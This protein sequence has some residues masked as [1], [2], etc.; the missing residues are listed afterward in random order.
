MAMEAIVSG[1]AARAAF[2][3][4]TE[5]FY[6][7]ADRPTD[8]IFI[9]RA[10]LREIFMDATDVESFI[11]RDYRESFPKLLVKFNSNRALAL[12]DIFLGL[13]FSN[14][15]RVS[16]ANEFMDLLFEDGVKNEIE[17]YL[18]SKENNLLKFEREFFGNPIKDARFFEYL[19]FIESCQEFIKETRRSLEIALKSVGSSWESS[20]E[21]ES[22]AISLGIFS[23]FVRAKA[24]NEKANNL[25]LD[26]HLKLAK[27]PQS[28]EIITNWTRSL[29]DKKARLDLQAILREEEAS[30]KEA[31]Y[32]PSEFVPGHELYQ[33]VLRQQGAIIEKI[34]DG[35]IA[36]ARKFADELI[37]HQ[38][39]SSS[40]NFAAKSLSKLAMEA[41]KFGRQ[42]LELEWARRALELA[43]NDGHAAGIAADTYLKLARLEEAQEAFE[44]VI[45][46]GVSAFGRAGLARVLRASGKLDEAL[47]ELQNLLD[48][49]ADG[50]EQREFVWFSYCSVL[51][52]MWRFDDALAAVRISRKEFSNSFL[53]EVTE[54]AILA[55]LGDLDAALEI[56]Q[57]ASV[58]HPEE[59][60]S[61]CG[62]AS[63][64]Q[65][66]GRIDEAEQTYASAHKRFQADPR[67]LVGLANALR[68]SGKFAEANAC[69]NDAISSYPFESSAYCGLAENF[70]DVGDIPSAIAA[71][72]SARSKF[73]LDAVV[74]CGRAN[75][76]K[77][78]GDF[79][80]ALRAYEEN[81][82]DF[83]YDLVSMGG[84]ADLLRRLGR[85]EEALKAYDDLVV[86][87]PN[88][89]APLI[90]KAAVL[91]AQG[92]YDEA[93]EILP[94]RQPRTERDWVSLHV[95]GMSYLGR[96][97]ITGALEIFSKAKEVPFF[98]QRKFFETAWANTLMRTK[99][100]GEAEEMLQK[101]SEDV[102]KILLM[103]TQLELGKSKE[104]MRIFSPANDN[105]PDP[106]HEL[107]L[108]IEAHFGISRERA[109]HDYEWILK[110]EI[111][112]Q[113]MVA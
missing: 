3:Q 8:K 4:G 54:A 41:R 43:P 111:E 36:K 46:F 82:K 39:S 25:I 1:E 50:D 27:L 96:G 75:M 31:A 61:F 5:I 47:A 23:S 87:H 77:V 12:L 10:T 80:G 34:K 56:Y 21:F 66:M 88:K 42:T 97:N 64:L 51:R 94:D 65:K 44:R 70:R 35:D 72:E 58:L 90:A 11:V 76:L 91:V 113:L 33:S 17:K 62:S 24:L 52:D 14:A 93:E 63:V 71:Y 15:L 103:R 9:N 6:I 85:F 45:N 106:V 22:Q 105:L 67:P 38:L 29:I 83:P 18:L 60:L 98:R 30:E 86:R 108:E 104:A 99:Q 40:K 53:L 79:E 69:F 19:N 74:R 32:R 55:D 2:V 20:V 92:R 102:A 16:A 84:R 109:K 13:N 81:L 28:R 68:E 48:E 59:V 37:R 78:A 110:R 95:R 101:H 107:K 7:D 26:A 100:F 89:E 73:P 112:V 49:L 57:Q